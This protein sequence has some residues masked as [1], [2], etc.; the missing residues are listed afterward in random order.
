MF[1]TNPSYLLEEQYVT[2]AN[3]GNRSHLHDRYG[4]SPIPFRAWEAGL[5]N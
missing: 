4:T 1:W 5:V 3:L 2:S